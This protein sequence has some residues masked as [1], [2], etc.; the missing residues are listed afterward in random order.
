MQSRKRISG[1]RAVPAI[2]APALLIWGTK[3]R[4]FAPKYVAKIKALSDNLETLSLEGVDHWPHLE[5]EQ[6]VTDTI[7]NHISIVLAN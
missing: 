5:R 3:D 6:E 2:K 7:R 4:V 1:L